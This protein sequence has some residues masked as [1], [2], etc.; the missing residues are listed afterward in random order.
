MTLYRQSEKNIGKT[1]LLWLLWSL[2][3]GVVIGVGCGGDA[4][5]P[6][7]VNTEHGIQIDYPSSWTPADQGRLGVLLKPAS[8]SSPVVHLL[9]EPLPAGVTNLDELIKHSLPSLQQRHPQ[10]D[11]DPVDIT[12]LSGEEGREIRWKSKFNI[13]TRAVMTI[14]NGR[15]YQVIFSGQEKPYDE[16]L[17]SVEKMISSFRIL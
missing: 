3:F 14:K 16:W 11:F 13:K 10:S 15:V 12:T 5:F 1:W 9:I 17:P 8:A 7:Y 4:K 2:F 6:R